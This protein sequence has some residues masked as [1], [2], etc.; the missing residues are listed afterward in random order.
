METYRVT[1][2][3]MLG[4]HEVLHTGLTLDEAKEICRSPESSSRTCTSRE[5]LDRTTRL[6]CAWFLGYEKE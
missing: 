3:V 6:G 5:G 1:L 2:F 4:E